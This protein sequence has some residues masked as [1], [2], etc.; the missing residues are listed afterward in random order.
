M[1]S[2]SWTLPSWIT[3]LKGDLLN[4]GAKRLQLKSTELST[5]AV[6]SQNWVIQFVRRSKT[7]FSDSHL[8]AT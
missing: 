5:I 6:F 3:S 1:L 2:M 8:L 4:P 7:E